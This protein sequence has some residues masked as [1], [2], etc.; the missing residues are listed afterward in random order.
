MI[1][2]I[3][4]P[5]VG[6]IGQRMTKHL[7]PLSCDVYVHANIFYTSDQT[8][9][10]EQ[11]GPSGEEEEDSEEEQAEGEEREERKRYQLRERRPIQPNLYQPSFG[12]QASRHVLSHLAELL[13]ECCLAVLS[14]KLL[15]VRTCTTH[16][17]VVLHDHGLENGHPLNR[18]HFSVYHG[19]DISFVKHPQLVTSLSTDV[20]LV[21]RVSHSI[22]DSDAGGTGW[23][24]VAR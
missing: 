11:A 3:N 12:G 23:Y 15:V 17:L 16:A 9:C 10:H 19:S 1:N 6:N 13:A 24:G 14:V 20:C 5:N 18:L 22:P 8:S 2:C 21:Y 4:E 7:L